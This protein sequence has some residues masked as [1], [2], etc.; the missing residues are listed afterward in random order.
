ML[1]RDV[2]PQN[3][4]F[5]IEVTPF[6]IVT[7]VRDV[8]FSNASL[9]IEV[10]PFITTVFK[11]LLRTYEIAIVGIVAFSIGQSENA[12]FPTSVT[13]SGITMLESFSQP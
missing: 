9:S 7:L 10:P 3:A 12:L 6:P 8:Q 1:V 2:Q 4:P 11:L 5:P 13:L